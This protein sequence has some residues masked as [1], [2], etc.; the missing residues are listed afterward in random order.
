MRGVCFMCNVLCFHIMDSMFLCVL[1]LCVLE[2]AFNFVVWNYNDNK[3]NSIQ[4]KALDLLPVLSLALLHPSDTNT[5][6]TLWLPH[7]SHHLLTTPSAPFEDLH[8]KNSSANSEGEEGKNSLPAPRSSPPSDV[9][10]DGPLSPSEDLYSYND[11]IEIIMK[12]LV[13][14]QIGT[15][16]KRYHLWSRP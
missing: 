12:S 3:V 14:F 16:S 4:S 5:S 11:L 13:T 10:D 6:L 2:M 7:N 8:F 1:L 15:T 9:Q